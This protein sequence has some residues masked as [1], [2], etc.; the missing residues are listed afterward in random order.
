MADILIVYDS[1]GGNTERMAMM[2]KEGVE[3]EGPDADARPVTEVHPEELL[4]AKGIILGSIS[5]LGNISA[6]MKEFL[7]ETVAFHGSLDGKVGGVFSSASHV[8][9]GNETTNLNLLQAMLIHGMV[10][11]GMVEE[12]HY[13]ALSVEMI[14]E[15][16]R[17]TVLHDGS[18]KRLGREVA[19]LVKKLFG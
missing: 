1:V 8:G 10:V 6:P 16:G 15:E 13:G 17:S 7:D 18:S 14:D 5:R 19:R 3:E 2:I 11:K 4:K 12:D 9:G